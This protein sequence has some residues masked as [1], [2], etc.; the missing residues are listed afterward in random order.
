M[1]TRLAALFCAL[2]LGWT[3]PALAAGLR[4]G[5]TQFPSTLHPLIDSMLAK[6]YV[7]AMTRRPIT[8][9]DQ[10]WELVCMLCTELPTIENG[11]AVPETLADG[12]QGIAVTYTIHPEATWGD[13]TPVTTRDLVFTWEVGRHPKSGVSDLETFRRILEVDVIDDKTAVLHVDRITFD[14]NAFGLDLLPEHIERAIFEAA[15]EAYRTRTAFDADPAN[16]GLAF[17]PYR[18]V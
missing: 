4:I 18:I 8:A 10:D 12:K 3:A 14:Y 7:L 11:L 13:G 1:V 6:S 5:I 17:G 2:I 15:P 16:P 9:F